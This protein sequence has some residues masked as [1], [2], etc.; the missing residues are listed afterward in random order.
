MLTYEG[1]G[2]WGPNYCILIVPLGTHGIPWDTGF[3]GM[4]PECKA[5][6]KA[7]CKSEYTDECK[8]VAVPWGRA[9]HMKLE[10]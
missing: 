9:L 3:P 10:T 6:R 7:E 4:N 2:S 5:E 1:H 8:A